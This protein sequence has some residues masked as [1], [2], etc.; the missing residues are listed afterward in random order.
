MMCCCGFHRADITM[1]YL[2]QNGNATMIINAP[3]VVWML[4]KHLAIWITFSMIKV[5]MHLFISNSQQND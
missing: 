2:K 4:I 5:K 3:L 1:N